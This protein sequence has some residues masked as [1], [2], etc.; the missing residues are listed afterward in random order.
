VGIPPPAEHRRP[1]GVSLVHPNTNAL[2]ILIVD[3]N[4]DA[5]DS[6]AVLLELLHYEVRVAYAGLDGLLVARMFAPDC[7]LT[8][9]SMPGLNGYELARRVRAEPVLASVKLVAL[10]A[11]TGDDHIRKATE[12]G[13]DYRLTKGCDLNT[14]LEVLKMIEEIK[15]L[16][17]RTQ[18]LAHRNV[19]LAGQTKDLIREVKE[20]VKEVKKEVKE[21]KQEVKELREERKKSADEN[22]N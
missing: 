19:E 8:D 7:M 22:G 21:L 10:S 2:R 1:S 15:H 20:D 9:I 17:T 14:I 13:F 12:A 5:A 11:F 4:H 6:L 16:A 3:D 18:E